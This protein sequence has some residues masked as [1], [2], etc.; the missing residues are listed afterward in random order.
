MVS[1]I[2]IYLNILNLRCFS[3]YWYT[4]FI[5]GI[6]LFL[7]ICCAMWSPKNFNDVTCILLCRHS[8]SRSRSR[9]RDV[10]PK[11]EIKQESSPPRLKQEDIKT[12]VTEETDNEKAVNGCVVSASCR[13]YSL[14]LKEY[15][16][17]AL[18][19][20]QFRS[21][22]ILCFSYKLELA[23]SYG[24]LKMKLKLYKYA[25]EHIIYMRKLQEYCDI[26]PVTHTHFLSID[27]SV[28][29]VL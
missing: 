21:L 28:V 27:L 11:K 18:I 22:V 4:L 20:V 13:S 14:T 12:E 1:E 29:H 10:S 17:I 2:I 9:N 25:Y 3:D 7:C 24:V 5:K 8:R 26:P 19:P 16:C 23:I 15:I 6:T